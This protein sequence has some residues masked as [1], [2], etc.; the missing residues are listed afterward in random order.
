MLFFPAMGTD[1]LHGPGQAGSIIKG[2]GSKIPAPCRAAGKIISHLTPNIEL[3]WVPSC[4]GFS[5]L[6]IHDKSQR[7]IWGDD[8]V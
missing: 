8:N 6:T 5:L 7:E 4:N 2:R 3:L 1:T